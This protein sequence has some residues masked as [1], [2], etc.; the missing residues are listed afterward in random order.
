MFFD[1]ELGFP[2]RKE[3]DSIV[4]FIKEKSE[5]IDKA[6]TLQQQQIAR[7][8]EYKATLINSA[9]T[10]KIKVTDEVVA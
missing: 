9:V 1:M 10:G 4:T 5:K 6:I 7:L 2:S 3:Q 8:K